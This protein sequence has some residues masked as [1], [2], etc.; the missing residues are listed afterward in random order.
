MLGVVRVGDI[1]SGHGCFPP[2]S[3]MTS[4]P[5]VFVDNL[6]VMRSGD[7]LQPHCC[8]DHGCHIGIYLG[9]NLVYANNMS[10]QKQ[11][12][13]ISCGSICLQASSTTFI[14]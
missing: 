8:P 10:I 11:G 5:D 6:A 12:D 1:D 2:R 14:G 3:N 9:S 13:P 4:S 7:I